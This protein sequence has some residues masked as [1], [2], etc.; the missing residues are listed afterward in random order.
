MDDCRHLRVYRIKKTIELYRKDGDYYIY[1]DAISDNE[2]TDYFYCF[3]CRKELV[4]RRIGD[5]SNKLRK[6]GT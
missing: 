2:G 5:K 3:Y 4:F 6:Y 1:D